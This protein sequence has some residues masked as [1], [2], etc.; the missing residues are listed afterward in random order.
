MATC[1]KTWQK[2]NWVNFLQNRIFCY[3]KV[4]SFWETLWCKKIIPTCLSRSWSRSGVEY[5]IRKIDKTGSTQRQVCSGRPR[6]VRCSEAINEVEDL[7]VSQEDKPQSHSTQR[8]ISWQLKISLGSVNRIVKQ[9][10]RLKCFKKCRATELTA[11]NKI[12]LETVARTLSRQSR[13]FY[14][15]HWRKIVYHSSSF[16]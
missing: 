15:L 11:A 16:K 6:S 10:L 2:C 13:K 1:D 7:I 3:Y 4:F 9:D 5:V 12:A 14:F 8:E